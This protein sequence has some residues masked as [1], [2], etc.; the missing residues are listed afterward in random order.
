MKETDFAY[1]LTRFLTLYLPSQR[2]IKMNT[3]L[4]YRDTFSLFLEYCKSEENIQPESLRIAQ[5]DRELIIR[6]LSW[7]EEIRNCKPAT[8][9]QRLAA[10]HSFFR[11][12]IIET[13]ENI[14]R[15]Q[16]I[17]NIPMKKGE[18]PMIKYL[19]LDGTK[20][21]LEQPDTTTIF[22][23]RD[24]TMLTLMYDTGCRVQELVDLRV[25]DITIGDS[26]TIKL[27]GKGGKSRIV[28]V[29]SPTGQLIRQ[30][31]DENN[32]GTPVYRNHP[33][34]TNRSGK[35]MTRA[36]VTYIL[37]KYAEMA[38]MKGH[39]DVD[40][41]LTPHCLRHSKAMHLLQSGVNLVYIRDLLGHAD[42]STTEVYA[43]A[44]EK[45]KREA[46]ENAY[47]SPSDGEMPTWQKDS[48]LLE[49]LKKFGKK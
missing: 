12:L 26:V 38:N 23:R 16:Q 13:P 30:Y 39:D 3:Q 15:A 45:M 42:V 43:R 40:P 5:I 41:K 20:A 21:L 32:L 2:G 19:S 34:F 48:G 27:T 4:S 47:E 11:Y 28:P 14:E 37:Q 18:N 17:L 44:D 29:M 6:F 24:G 7:L 25:C 10:I 22:G 36:G 35:K 49:W 46:L 8:R 33:L 9:N 1:H 31:I